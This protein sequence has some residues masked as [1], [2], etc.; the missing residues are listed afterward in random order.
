M[1]A[2]LLVPLL[3]TGHA[4]QGKIDSKQISYDYPKCNMDNPLVVTADLAGKPWF[5]ATGKIDTNVPVTGVL[6]DPDNPMTPIPGVTDPLNKGLTGASGVWNIGFSPPPDPKHGY[7][8][9]VTTVDGSESQDCTFNLLPA[10]EGKY[11]APTGCK[12]DRDKSDT[13]VLGGKRYFQIHGI[14]K[15]AN[16]TFVHGDL[17]VK[18]TEEGKVK[19]KVIYGKTYLTPVTVESRPMTAVMVEIELPESFSGHVTVRLQSYW[20]NGSDAFTKEIKK[21]GG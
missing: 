10:K 19:Y 7:L 4:T 21:K 6:F 13:V 3:A 2:V 8:L 18:T 12:I 20:P 16:P 5:V 14:V 1:I 11:G 9:R 17:V 15:A